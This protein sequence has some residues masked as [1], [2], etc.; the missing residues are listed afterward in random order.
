LFRQGFL[1]PG[2][3]DSPSFCSAH[4]GNRM[5]LSPVQVHDNECGHSALPALERPISCRHCLCSQQST[6][7]TSQSFRQRNVRIAQGVRYVGFDAL[8]AVAMGY[9][10]MYSFQI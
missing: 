7:V 8:T 1:G 5:E 2:D 6:E 9:N 3:S 10:A 4:H